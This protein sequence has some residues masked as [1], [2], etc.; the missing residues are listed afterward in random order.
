MSKLI[1]EIKAFKDNGEYET[2]WTDVTRDVVAIGDFSVTLDN[3]E[4]NTG[5][6]KNSTS[7]IS[8]SNESGKYA[9]VGA[10]NSIFNY[11]RNNS[12]VRISWNKTTIAPICG[13]A[14]AGEA[15]L[16][17]D[18]SIVFAGLLNDESVKT[19]IKDQQA[20]FKLL[21]KESKFSQVETPFSSIT[22]GDSFEDI[23]YTILNQTD[24]TQLLTVSA[25]NINVGTNQL[26]DDKSDWENTTVQ[27][28]LSEVL[29]MSGSILYI[30]SEIY[31]YKI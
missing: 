25:S 22:V 5:T 28:V 15:V 26:I 27:E 7:S 23:L 31:K 9:E 20:K 30:N 3:D 8:F 19:D 6:F 29:E 1:V 17:G 21:G 4:Y 24:I 2:S 12:Q 16:A 18:N 10:P 14:I 13:I 11:T